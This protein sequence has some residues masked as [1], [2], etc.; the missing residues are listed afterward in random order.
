MAFVVVPQYLVEAL[1]P[2]LATDPNMGHV[3]AEQ[4]L[5]TDPQAGIIA[6]ISGEAAGKALSVGDKVALPP[7][8]NNRSWDQLADEL[9]VAAKAALG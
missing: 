6:R 3:L 7:P 8:V 4:V 2:A 5:R 9:R 1:A